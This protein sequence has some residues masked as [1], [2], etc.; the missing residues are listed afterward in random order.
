MDENKFRK[1]FGITIA[2]G[3]VSLIA[4]EW[5]RDRYATPEQRL[6]RITPGF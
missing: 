5:Y 4:Y 2:A 1:M 3:M 6:K